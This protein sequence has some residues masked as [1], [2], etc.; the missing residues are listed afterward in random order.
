MAEL[1]KNGAPLPRGKHARIVQG[2]AE[3]AAVCD[4]LSG[5][6]GAQHR[7]QQAPNPPD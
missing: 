4:S 5:L 1:Q 7:L 6:G 3:Y 2:K